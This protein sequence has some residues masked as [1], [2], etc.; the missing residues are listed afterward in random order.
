MLIKLVP[1]TAQVTASVWEGTV[2]VSQGSR[3][4]FSVTVLS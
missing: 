3:Q 4:D 2:A 1:T